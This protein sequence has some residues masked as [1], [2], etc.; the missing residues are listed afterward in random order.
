MLAECLPSDTSQNLKFIKLASVPFLLSQSHLWGL[1][2][3][4]DWGPSLW[5]GLYVCPAWPSSSIQSMTSSHHSISKEFWT[6][7]SLLPLPSALIQA[8][9]FTSLDNHSSFLKWLPLSASSN[10]PS[11]CQR[12]R[13]KNIIRCETAQL[14]TFHGFLWHLKIKSRLTYGCVT[15]GPCFCPNLIPLGIQHSSMLRCLKMEV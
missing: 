1:H 3:N 9:I 5:I 7:H 15:P 10:S 13:F 4:W 6:L 14:K 2:F 8:L 12:D 11:I